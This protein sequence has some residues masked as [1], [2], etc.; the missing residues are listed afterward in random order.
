MVIDQDKKAK[1]EQKAKKD[2]LR[3]ET[4]QIQQFNYQQSG[5]YI[6]SEAYG[7]AAVET[8]SHCTSLNKKKRINAGGG[9][10]NMEEARFNKGLLKEISMM[11]KQE[12]LSQVPNELNSRHQKSDVG[13]SPNQK[14]AMSKY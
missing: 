6:S 3:N 14:S 10:M 8:G 7:N 11:K 5:E 2:R 12:R 13:N 4:K 1:E 9:P